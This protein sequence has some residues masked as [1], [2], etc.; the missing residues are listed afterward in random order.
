MF[1]HKMS[2]ITD[3]RYLE[4]LDGLNEVYLTKIMQDYADS[5]QS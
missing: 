1:L 5:L 2:I 3:E 4:I